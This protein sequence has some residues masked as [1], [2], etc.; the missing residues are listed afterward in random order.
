MENCRARLG[1]KSDT[2]HLFRIKNLSNLL[3]SS[4]IG[5]KSRELE[6]EIVMKGAIQAQ[7]LHEH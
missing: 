5:E 1:T 3:I 6:A 7:S 4:S 2:K